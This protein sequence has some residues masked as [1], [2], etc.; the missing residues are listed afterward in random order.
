MKAAWSACHWAVRRVAV[1]GESPADPVVR[2][3]VRRRGG[4]HSQNLHSSVGV[5]DVDGDLVELIHGIT[6]ALR[7]ELGE[8]DRYP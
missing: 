5:V 8:V 2:T 6:E 4:C 3:G 7:P 1:A